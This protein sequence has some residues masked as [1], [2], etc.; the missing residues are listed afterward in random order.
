MKN[1]YVFYGEEDFLISKAILE[2]KNNNKDGQVVTYDLSQTNISDLLEDA[3]SLSLFGG[4][5]I[6]IGYNANFLSGNP[7]KDSIDHHLNDLDRYIDNPNPD[8]IIILVV[9]SDKLDKRKSIVKKI[10]EKADVREFNKLS[11]DE[12]VKYAKNIF[13]NHNYQTT[14]KTLNILIDKVGNNLYLLNSECE[15]LMIYKMEDKIIDETSVEEMVDKYDFDNIFTLTD[16][17]IRKDINTSL[18]LYQELLKRNE[19][20]IKIIVMLANQFRLIF[21]VKRLSSKGLSESQIARELDVHPYRVK[22]AK[23]VK[24]NDKELLHFIE[25]LA[26]LDENIK[27]G[28]I[29]KDVGL[30][31]FILK[32]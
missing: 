3:S 21:Q 15:K 25:L 8:S 14:F 1:M 10:N 5:K 7:A 2:I 30:E 32:L 23:E 9:P 11:E 19:E 13:S 22:L 12:M 31:L 24:L 18:I 17:I 6:I 26:D 16:A 27:M 20:P 28:K 4:K 29:N